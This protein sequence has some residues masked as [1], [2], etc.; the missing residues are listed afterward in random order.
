ME[1]SKE[2][3]NNFKTEFYP[4]VVNSDIIEGVPLATLA[5][6]SVD[7]FIR[8]PLRGKG[9]EVSSGRIYQ[10]MARKGFLLHFCPF[11]FFF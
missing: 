1:N 6:Q 7:F 11:L 5:G 8:S 10:D 2:K 9:R 3:N 4:Q